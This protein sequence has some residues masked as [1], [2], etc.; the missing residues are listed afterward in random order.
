MNPS[1]QAIISPPERRATPLIAFRARLDRRA[2]LIG[3]AVAG[4]AAGLFLGWDWLAAAGFTSV[5][6]GFLPCAALCAAGMCAGRHGSKDSCQRKSET[7]SGAA[8]PEDKA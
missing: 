1:E 6:V 5:I 3:L 2:V 4:I 7:G 8:L